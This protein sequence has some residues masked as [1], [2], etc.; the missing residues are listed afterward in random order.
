MASS[1]FNIPGD[2][3]TKF[4]PFRMNGNGIQKFS[5]RNSSGFGQLNICPS[6][7][8][9]NFSQDIAVKQL[10][11]INGKTKLELNDILQEIPAIQIREFLPDTKLDQTINFFGTIIDR[12]KDLWADHQ[13]KAKED[14]KNTKSKGA[15]TRAKEQAATNSFLGKMKEILMKAF[16]ILTGKDFINA[17][18][19]N[20]EQITATCGND[21]DLCNYVLKFPYTFYYNLQSCQNT[22]I[23]ELPC[24]QSDKRILTSDGTPG[25]EAGTGFKVGGLL[26]KIPLIGS[27]LSNILGNIGIHYM[28]WWDSDAGIKVPEPEIE[29]KFDLFNDTVE[30]ALVNFIFV[31]TLLPNN[32]W[33]QYGM[34]QHSSCLYDIKL[35]GINRLFACAGKFAVTYD[36]VLRSPSQKFFDDLK[37]K[38]TSGLTYTPQEIKIPDVYHVQMN[39]T[40]LVPAN[41]NNY[42]YSMLYNNNLTTLTTTHTDGVFGKIVGDGI[43]KVTED[44]IAI[45]S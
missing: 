26:T 9:D 40:S 16:D 17:I 24:I 25:W 44:V 30:A 5:F 33:I 3:K 19:G 8:K 11:G 4:L 15:E 22:G 6:A 31:H 34:F 21:A 23:Y 43:K 39:F 29:I 20:F 37:A 18:Q 13:D 2:I 10:Y 28:P 35:E 27:M 14:I 7:I 32:K 38:S 42:L 1:N 36:G 12:V 45:I 41:F